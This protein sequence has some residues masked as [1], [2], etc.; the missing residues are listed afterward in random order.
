[1]LSVHYC[2]KSCLGL[3]EPTAR[4]MPPFLN[5][6][7]KGNTMQSVY[8]LKMPKTW[9]RSNEIVACLRQQT[10]FCSSRFIF[11]SWRYF[12]QNTEPKQSCTWAA[13][14][15][16]HSLQ[17]LFSTTHTTDQLQRQ[18]SSRA[19]VAARCQS[20]WSWTS[21]T[22][23]LQSTLQSPWLQPGSG[24][25]SLAPCYASAATELRNSTGWKLQ[26]PMLCVI[27]SVLL[28]RSNSSLYTASP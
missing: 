6:A 26:A 4:E 22:P 11:C 2:S 5:L 10:L 8:K 15:A 25:C 14:P 20:C 9:E 7:H 16:M 12:T 3:A 13:V 17:L 24:L 27:L 23:C 19:P 21:S 28:A 1:L 18:L